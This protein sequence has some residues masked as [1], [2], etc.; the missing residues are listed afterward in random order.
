MKILVCFGTRPEAIKMA[1]VIHELNT[2]K[3]NFKVCVT[4]QHREM[5]DQVLN[6]FEIIPDY[7]LSLMSPDQSLNKLSSEI[8]DAFDKVIS[9]FQP[10]LV[11]VH[12]DTTT[13]VM[14]AW[15][16]FHRNIKVAHVEAGLRTFTYH[17]PFPEE[18]NRQITARLA[19]HHFAPT[20]KAK[21][22]LLLENVTE[23][24]IYIT[25]NTIVDAVKLGLSKIEKLD[26]KELTLELDIDINKLEK[27]ILVT[28]HRRENFG[29]GLENLCE[30]LLEIASKTEVDIVYPVHLNPNVK[31]VIHEKLNGVS[32]IHL[33]EPVSYPIMLYLL[34][35]CELIISDSGG[36]QEEAPSFG[37]K[38]LVTREMSERTE[39]IESGNAIIV[40]TSKHK[41]VL[42]ASKIIQNSSKGILENPF[43]DGHAS[44]RIIEILNGKT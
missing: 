37:K 25:G 35:N 40:G 38:V 7:D 32:N 18:M 41:I 14:A 3:S 21:N 28:G 34:K 9:I 23:Q 10:D 24:N 27:F 13:S 30:A 8:L 4:G 5:L 26:M 17:A 1:P 2:S 31:K 43:G 36:I 33:I 16:A 39:A 15:A 19:S 22:N 42:E 29:D 6:F 20:L 44:S 11:M 12:G